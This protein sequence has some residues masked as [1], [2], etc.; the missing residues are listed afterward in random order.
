MNVMYAGFAG[1]KNLSRSLTT[2][3]MGDRS[4]NRLPGAISAIHIGNAK[5]RKKDQYDGWGIDFE[6][7]K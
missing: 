7:P 3:A 5:Y 2:T 6:L 4:E 1:A